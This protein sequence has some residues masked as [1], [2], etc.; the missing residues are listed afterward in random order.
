MRSTYPRY[1]DNATDELIVAIVDAMS[2]WFS[3]ERNEP[4]CTALYR[5]VSTINPDIKRR[6]TQY[7]LRRIYEPSAA[8]SDDLLPPGNMPYTLAEYIVAYCPPLSWDLYQGAL[9]GTIHALDLIAGGFSTVYHPADGLHHF[10]DEPFIGKSRILRVVQ[11]RKAGFVKPLFC[12]VP[13]SFH[14]ASISTPLGQA[15]CRLLVFIF[16]YLREHGCDWQYRSGILGIAKLAEDRGYRLA[17]TFEGEYFEEVA[18]P[19]CLEV[20][21][22]YEVYGKLPDGYPPRLDDYRKP[23]I[24]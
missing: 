9:I 4:H 24:F 3:D 23:G 1:P 5:A 2:D 15:L 22:Y 18:E 10:L 6:Y 20:E 19:P 16:G 14:D 7:R 12:S 13:P 8:G 21:A 11:S 17:R